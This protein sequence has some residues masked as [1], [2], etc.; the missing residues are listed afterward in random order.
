M[1]PSNAAVPVASPPKLIFLE[2][3]KCPSRLA[4]TIL[5]LKLP[6]PSLTTNVLA[7]LL[8][9]AFVLTVSVSVAASVVT[10][11]PPDPSTFKVAA[12]ASATMLL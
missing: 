11:I 4:V 6:E 9:V 7:V 12:A 5:A 3:T 2:L 10:T 1:L 8:L